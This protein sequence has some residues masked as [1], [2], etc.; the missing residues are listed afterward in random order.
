MDIERILYISQQIS[1]YLPENRMSVF[2]RALPQSIQEKGI[3]VR[4][5]MPKYGLINE[6]RNQLH[7]VIRLS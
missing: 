3:E 7:E 4:I 6:R 1:P 5:F 2:N